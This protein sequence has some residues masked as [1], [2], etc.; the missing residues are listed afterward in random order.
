[1]P[2]SAT[3][4][5]LPAAIMAA[6]SL[7]ICVVKRGFVMA[8]WAS[9]TAARILPSRGNFAAR[10]MAARHSPAAMWL[11][12]VSIFFMGAGVVCMDSTLRNTPE[13]S[14]EQPSVVLG[15]LGQLDGSRAPLPGVNG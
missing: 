15:F 3:S 9:S 1:M 14:S 4:A 8:M 5:S 13:M 10:L 6:G 7:P 12:K 11:R 2:Y